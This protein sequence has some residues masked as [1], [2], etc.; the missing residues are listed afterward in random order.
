MHYLY[1]RNIRLMGE[2]GWDVEREQARFILGSM[3]AF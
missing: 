3:F 1:K 2:L